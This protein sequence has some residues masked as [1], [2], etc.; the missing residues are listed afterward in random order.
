MSYKKRQNIKQN[1]QKILKILAKK[2][3][4]VLTLSNHGCE[5]P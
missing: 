5:H 3:S 4:K 2:C 1:N